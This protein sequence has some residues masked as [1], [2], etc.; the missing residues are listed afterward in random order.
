MPGDGI[1]TYED[2]PLKTPYPF[3]AISRDISIINNPKMTC[4]LNRLEGY[5]DVGQDN[6]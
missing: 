3:V 4:I 1:P 2:Q 5:N 6:S